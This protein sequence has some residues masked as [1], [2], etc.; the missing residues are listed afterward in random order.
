VGPARPCR[1]RQNGYHEFVISISEKRAVRV[2]RYL[3][4]SRDDQDPRLQADETAQLI[5][6]RRWNLYETFLDH[7]VSGS[8]DR[9][10][11]LD[12][13]MADARRG[14]FDVLLV[15]RADRLFRS[16]RHM[17][18]ALDELAA[19]GI[20]FV[21]VTE[22]FDTTSPQGRLLLTLV[23][24]FSEFEKCVLIERTRAG[25][26]AARRAG[27]RVGRPRVH[28]DVDSARRMR[29]AGKTTKAIAAALGCGA[30]TLR[31]ALA[32]DARVREAQGEPNAGGDFDQGQ[33]ANAA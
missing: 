11:A 23:S 15:W 12:R 24:A 32:A 33:S 1:A 22:S 26:A 17:V 14:K 7:G 9:R 25:I 19:L 2:A 16:L 13:L 4:V 31:R 8:K 10:P 27:V 5:A 20:D 21:S 3:R 30:T 28:V 18:V 6:H 29:A